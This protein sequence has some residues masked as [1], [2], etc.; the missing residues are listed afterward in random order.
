[1]ILF[2]VRVCAGDLLER[3]PVF[4]H[5]L[6][7]LLAHASALCLVAGVRTG[8]PG[9]DGPQRAESDVFAHLGGVRDT[10]N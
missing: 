10:S 4:D 8:Q 7:A 3:I 5:G 2:D 6:H 1:V 9:G